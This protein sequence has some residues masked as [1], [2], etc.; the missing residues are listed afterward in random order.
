MTKPSWYE[1]RIVP[2]IVRLGCGC[3]LMAPYRERIVP[4]ASGHVLELGIGAGANFP[5]YDAARVEHVTGIEPSAELRAMALAAA[6]NAGIANDVID[7]SAE[8]LPFADASFDTVLTTFTLCS[9]A[10][11]LAALAEARRV[12]RPGGRLL[13]CEHGMADDSATRQRQQ[14]WDPLWSRVF[15]GCHINRPVKG[16]IAR[17]FESVD[18]EAGFQGKRPSLGGWMEW[19]EANA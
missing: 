8:A 15:G 19:G 9:V 14:R 3:R 11:N 7:A 10:D 6:R 17:V 12:L 5:F 4:K 16:T 18:A 2:H 13:F 1:R